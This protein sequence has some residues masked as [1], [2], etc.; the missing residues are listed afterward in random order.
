LH[1]TLQ[2]M[3]K[4]AENIRRLRM[5]AGM[6][7]QELADRLHLS[8]SSIAN[9]ETGSRQPGMDVIASLSAVF[10]VPVA[11]LLGLDESPSEERE[12]QGGA[13]SLAALSKEA[14][15]SL[16]AFYSFLLSGENVFVPR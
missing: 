11:S 10:Q 12:E 16:L 6:T 2:T 1:E 9:Y 13:L 5:R 14:K 15:A 8:R 3:D 4:T 7:Q